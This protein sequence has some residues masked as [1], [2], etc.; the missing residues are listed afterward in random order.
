[1]I[2][3][4]DRRWERLELRHL[5]A[6]AAVARTGSF[7]AGAAELGYSQSALSGQ[8][9]G[10]EQI[11]DQPVVTR[12]GGR[13]AVAITP[14]GR[15]L[16]AHGEGIA[17]R[18]AAAR[19]DL[20]AIRVQRSSLR[21]GIYQSVAVRLLPGIVR[22]LASIRADLEI[23]LTEHAD[24]GHLL[25]L[26]ARGELDATAVALPVPA[27][28]FA[29]APLL[30]ESYLVLVAADSPLAARDSIAPEELASHGLI[31]YRELR[32]IHRSWARLPRDARPTIVARTD[33]NPTIHALVAAGIGVAILPRLS[34]NANDPAVR[35]VPLVPAPPPRRVA[36][37]WHQD[38]RPDGLDDL[39]AAARQEAESYDSPARRS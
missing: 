24:D 6:L 1:M 32:Q 2:E 39:L 16:L 27:G 20:E 5:V 12:P 14:A 8:I 13:R 4:L 11:V 29:T 17:A 34:I 36:L 25:D 10:L 18:V 7:R 38:R 28:P 37:A 30:D 15:C 3:G 23:E 21:L 26:V 33:D 9:A 22:R 19:A 35:A 31:D